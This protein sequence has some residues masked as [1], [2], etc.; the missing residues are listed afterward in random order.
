LREAG[1]HETLLPLFTGT[2]V[3][4]KLV[5]KSMRFSDVFISP[6]IR[7]G[8]TKGMANNKKISSPWVT[9]RDSRI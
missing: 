6:G 5:H 4:A 9:P 3:A 1:T 2:L 7:S 8:G